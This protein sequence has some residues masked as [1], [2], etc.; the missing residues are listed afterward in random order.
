MEITS[1]QFHEEIR[2][3]EQRLDQKLDQKLK[4]VKEG[5]I[6]WIAGIFIGA[7][8]LTLSAIGLYT[9]TLIGMAGLERLP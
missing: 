8:L 4:D 7:L 5:V 9:A 2:N 1:E 3:L 6:K